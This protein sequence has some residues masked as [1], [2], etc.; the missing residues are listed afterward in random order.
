MDFEELLKELKSELG[1]LIEE[2]FSDFK[3]AAQEDV[4]EFIESSRTK[5]KRWTGLL[6]QGELDREEYSWLLKSQKDLFLM[7]ALKKAGMEKLRLEKLKDGMVD[8]I[9]DTAFRVVL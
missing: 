7:H 9:L 4:D 5:L 8:V 1:Q 3:D 2:N 6:A